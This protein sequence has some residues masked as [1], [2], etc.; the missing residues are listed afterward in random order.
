KQPAEQRA[1]L[2]VGDGHAVV[3]ADEE[4]VEPGIAC[5][6]RPLDHPPRP[7]APILDHVAAA[8]RGAEPHEPAGARSTASTVALASTRSAGTS[9]VSSPCGSSVSES[10]MPVR[11]LWRSSA[12]VARACTDST[13][14][15]GTPRTVTDSYG[16]MSRCR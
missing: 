12:P 16:R 8:Q 7:G 13:R 9:I 2:V 10:M 15:I 4:R 11:V 6:P 3:V 1:V 14:L 5:R